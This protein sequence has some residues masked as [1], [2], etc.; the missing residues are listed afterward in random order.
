MPL[1]KIKAIKWCI[2]TRK[3]RFFYGSAGRVKA[4]HQVEQMVDSL[5]A[6]MEVWIK[7]RR[8]L[9]LFRGVNSV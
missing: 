8:L 7:G 1:I 3:V 4:C 2:N 9:F 6:E 5:H